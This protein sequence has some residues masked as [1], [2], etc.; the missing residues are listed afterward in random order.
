MEISKKDEALA[1]QA[2]CLA[3]DVRNGLISTTWIQKSFQLSY[4]HAARLM[5]YL[6]KKGYVVD[7]GSNGLKSYKAVLE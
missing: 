6:I 1:L 3:L 4:L 2:L 5:E 7:N